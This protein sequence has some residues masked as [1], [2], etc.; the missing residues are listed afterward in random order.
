ME[1]LVLNSSFLRFPG[2]PF[3]PSRRGARFRPA[4]VTTAA[5]AAAAAAH[6]VPRPDLDV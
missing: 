2:S 1:P 6:L 4:V 5:A 3:L